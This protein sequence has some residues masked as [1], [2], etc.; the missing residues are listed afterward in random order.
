MKK[1]NIEKILIESLSLTR[2]GV[3]IFDP[4]DRLIFGN[5]ALSTLFGIPVKEAINKT[6][7][8]LCH[9]CFKT[10]KGINIEAEH[11]E[12]WIDSALK[13][14]RQHN[15]RTFETDTIDGQYFI[16]TEQIVQKNFL[17][18]YLTDITD[19]KENE[20]KLTLMSQEL[21]NLATTDYLTGI[22]NRRYFYQMAQAEFSRSKRDNL[23]LTVLILDLDKFKLINDTYGHSAGDCVLKAVTNTINQLL[24]NYDIFARI[25][26]EEFAILLPSTDA[27]SGYIIAERIR[28][29]IESLKLPFENE[30]LKITTSIGML[31]I[32]DKIAS[33]EEMM[34]IADRS[35]NQVKSKGRNQ[36][37]CGFN[38]NYPA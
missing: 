11:F 34:K 2:D 3:G 5:E 36:V 24:R 4:D 15:Y 12:T 6:F 23:E 37:L 8:Q 19:K 29:A 14:R 32:N 21:E 13:K 28:V 35:L 33:F 1:Y 30:L 26:G 22:R 20:K 38:N 25:G 16:V 17:Y 31:E 7:T 27:Q 9:I 10:K 18:M